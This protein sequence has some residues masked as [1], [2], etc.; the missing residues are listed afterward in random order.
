VYRKPQAYTIAT[1]EGSTVA[2]GGTPLTL[3]RSP[4][5]AHFK[6]ALPAGVHNFP[7]EGPGV[8]SNEPVASQT[9][10]LCI[11][12]HTSSVMQPLQPMH[13]T[14]PALPIEATAHL[15]STVHDTA[16]GQSPDTAEQPTAHDSPPLHGDLDATMPSLM[17]QKKPGLQATNPRAAA[18]DAFD[19]NRMNLPGEEL[20]E[21]RG[22]LESLAWPSGTRARTGNGVLSEPASPM[23]GTVND[24]PMSAS[25]IFGPSST[26]GP[27][28]GDG[29]AIPSRGVPVSFHTNS[30]AGVQETALVGAEMPHVATT[31][32]QPH[33][34]QGSAGSAA[35][36]LISHQPTSTDGSATIA[37]KLANNMSPGAA[38]ST[39]V[40]THA[41]APSTLSSAMLKSTS[42]HVPSTTS[43]LNDFSHTSAGREVH[44]HTHSPALAASNSEFHATPLSPQQTA[45]SHAVRSASGPS[46]H[47]PPATALPCSVEESTAYYPTI[48]DACTSQHTPR[49]EQDTFWTKKPQQI[50]TLVQHVSQHGSSQH[51]AQSALES[52]SSVSPYVELVVE[53]AVAIDAPDPTPLPPCGSPILLLPQCH[54]HVH[55]SALPLCVLCLTVPPPVHRSQSD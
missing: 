44:S 34:R 6:P 48:A 39:F 40:A 53:E 47:S 25:A 29:H 24:W 45:G 33:R 51:S 1:P 35:N 12:V 13:G 5:T 16:A 50:D 14:D 38:H 11:P 8:P 10:R 42:G 17:P 21:S 20:L 36:P 2:S 49:N 30:Q 3:F 41:R 55:C 7:G 43:T 46:S 9:S 18:R 23:F 52:D 37:H 4:C 22:S 27:V 19:V 28:P 54:P 26:E 15:P 32:L 31:A